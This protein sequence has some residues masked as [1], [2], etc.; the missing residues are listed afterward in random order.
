VGYRAIQEMFRQRVRPALLDFGDAGNKFQGDAVLYLAFEGMDEVV[1]AEEKRALSVCERF[2]GKRLSRAEAERFWSDRHEIARRFMKN[3]RQRR[4]RGRDGVYR[5]WIHVA[6]PRQSLPFR[7]AAMG[8]ARNMGAILEAASGFQPELFPCLWVSGS[9]T[10]KAHFHWK[11]RSMNC[12]IGVENGGS[13][14]YT[15]GVE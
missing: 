14:E 5:D 1:S 3:R 6:L 11:K 13:M 10:N 7:A 8:I 4:E 12:C 9:G 2:G 15:H